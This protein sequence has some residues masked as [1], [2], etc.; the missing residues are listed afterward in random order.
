[1]CTCAREKKT[2]WYTEVK[3]SNTDEKRGC[4]S[5]SQILLAPE[6]V[7]VVVQ[8][9]AFNYVNWSLESLPFFLEMNKCSSQNYIHAADTDNR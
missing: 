5:G 3:K 6:E 4:S 1:M 8:S 9:L 2:F 7:V